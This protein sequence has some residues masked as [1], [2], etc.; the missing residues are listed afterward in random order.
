MR[1][2]RVCMMSER[3]AFG[4]DATEAVVK[5][6]IQGVEFLVGAAGSGVGFVGYGFK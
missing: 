4:G 5:L 1:V 3:S 6:L 2:S